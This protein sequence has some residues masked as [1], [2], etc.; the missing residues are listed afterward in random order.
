MK[1]SVVVTGSVAQRPGHAG[2]AWALLQWVLGFRRLGWQ[3][4]FLDRL[5]AGMAAA[6]PAAADPAWS[7]H[8]SE[9]VRTMRAFGLERQHALL[10]GD[11]TT[12]GLDRA[13]IERRVGDADFVLD[14]MGY[15][16]NADL[17]G[18]ARRRVFLDI[19]PGFGQMWHA[20]GLCDNYSGYDAFV[21]LG[22]NIGRPGCP[23]PTCGR[24]WIPTLHPVV[25]ELWPFTEPT[26]SSF[27]S[28]GAWR[29][30]YASVEYEGSSYGLRCHEF[31]R[32]LELPRLTG[33]PFQLAL[34]I[35]PVE[36]RDLAR[37]A[38]GGW[39]LLDPR[40]VAPGRDAYQAFIRG[41][42]AEFM[43][44]KN[45]YVRSRSGWFSDRSIAY[46]ASGRPVL[47]Q[48][49]GLAGHV[50]A[51]A[52]LLLFDSIDEAVAGAR[53]IRRAPARHARVAR[54]LAAAHFDSDVVLTAL[55]GRLG[56]TRA[57]A[58]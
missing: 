54:E 15:F 33:F 48:D 20:L 32:F 10:L 8:V 11:G 1:G 42:G 13:T 4:L 26:A 49:T 16:G 53:E 28:I 30:P 6:G 22:L 24:T 21:T 46:L 36:T 3:V 38:H 39:T 44:A 50:Q 45:M 17:L 27:T 58:A 51:G 41:S 43:V 12:V 23:I 55:L 29:W 37:L 18:R 7:R 5:D 52:G 19:D 47:A 25:M 40:R 57:A 9:F 34:D 2:H 14:I 31:R 35:D 56:G